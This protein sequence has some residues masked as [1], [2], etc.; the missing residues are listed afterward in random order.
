MAG[1]PAVL[2]CACLAWSRFRVVVPLRDKTVPSMVIG[3][4]RTLRIFDGVPTSA[5]TGNEKTVTI[6]HVCGIPVRNPA[7]VGVSRHFGLMVQTYEPADPQSKGGSEATVKIAKAD[8]VP[9]DHNVRDEY[10]DWPAFE[11]ACE[12]FIALMNTR[13]HRATR[14]PP[15]VLLG[16]EH[17]HLHRVPRLSHTLCF[18]QTRK[19]DRQA[20]VS[21][22]EAIDSVP[23]ELGR[24][25]VWALAEGEQLVVVHVDELQGPREVGRHP[26]TTPGS[27]EH[28]RRALPATTG[29][30]VGAQAPRSQRRGAGVPS[31]RRAC[32]AVAQPSRGGGTHGSGARWPWRSIWPS[33]TAQGFSMRRWGGAPATAGSPTATWPASVAHQSIAAAIQLPTR[34]PE[35]RSLQRSTRSWEQFGRRPSTTGTSARRSIPSSRTRCPGG[36]R[37]QDVS[38]ILVDDPRGSEPVGIALLAFQHTSP[39]LSVAARRTGRP[40][41]DTAMTVKPPARYHYRTSSTGSM[42][43]VCVEL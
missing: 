3:L 25:A 23:H 33:S 17:E 1:V 35:E 7:I 20:T 19:V 26:M 12:R 24:R 39:V 4:D 38:V 21:V 29:G 10:P 18:G 36:G 27:P 31:D 30:R 28:R 11:Q 8:L 15:V 9:T 2:F 32:R 14:R 40:R 42:W 6:E 16:Q 43:I 22:G 41:K 34:A 13:Q 5:L 37:L